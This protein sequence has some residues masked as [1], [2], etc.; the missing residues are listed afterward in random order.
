GQGLLQIRDPL[1]PGYVLN[2]AVVPAHDPT[3]ITTLPNRADWYHVEGCAHLSIEAFGQMSK[4]VEVRYDRFLALGPG[5]TEP[6]AGL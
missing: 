1:S 5:R 2:P 6:L 4:V 3:L